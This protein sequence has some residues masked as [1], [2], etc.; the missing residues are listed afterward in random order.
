[1]QPERPPD[2]DEPQAYPPGEAAPATRGRRVRSRLGRLRVRGQRIGGA[3]F[4]T[5]LCDARSGDVGDGELVAGHAHEVALARRATERVPD[6]ARE[7]VAALRGDVPVGLAVEV[8]DL[9]AAERLEAAV[10]QLADRE[11]LLAVELVADL[12]DD[13][14]ED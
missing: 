10:G 4:D 2:A 9:Q 5:D 6:Q 7:C 14:L 12:A 1:M 11:Q 13:L 3:L 8:R